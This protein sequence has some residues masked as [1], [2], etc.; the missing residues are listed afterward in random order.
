MPVMPMMHMRPERVVEDPEPPEERSARASSVA[1]YEPLDLVVD[2]SHVYGEVYRPDGS[3]T[4]PRPC[5]CLFHGFPGVLNNDDLAFAL[6]RTGCV[7][8]RVFHRGAWGSEGFYSYSHCIEDA[9]A[10]ANWALEEGVARYDVDPD[11]L[12]LAGQSMGGQTALTATRLL[13]RVRGTVLMTPFDVSRVFRSGREDL[14]REA[15]AGE[16][17]VLHVEG[18]DSILEDAR[19]LWPRTD[20]EAHADELVGRDLLLIGGT[21]DDVAPVDEMLMPLW[22]RLQ[23]G[24]AEAETQGH[25]HGDHR[26]VLY[27]T[28]HG[29]CNSR[30]RMARDIAAWMSR[31]CGDEPGGEEADESRTAETTDMNEEN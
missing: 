10:L 15:I 27:P 23:E 9:V 13:D 31:L 16:G 5:V 26:L 24:D 3:F 22:R 28:E 1:S 6:Q 7:V 4:G 18:P 8:L 21:L 25:A 12:F 14:L 11:R 19:E 20:F 29:L 30:V 2:S 17:R